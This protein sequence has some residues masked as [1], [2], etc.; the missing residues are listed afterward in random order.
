MGWR[1]RPVSQGVGFWCCERCLWCDRKGWRCVSKCLLAQGHVAREG[2]DQ[3]ENIEMFARLV[4]DIEIAV[5]GL[6]HQVWKQKLK[7]FL[8]LIHAWHTFHS[9]I[10]LEPLR[11]LNSETQSCLEYP[12][13]LLSPH[14]SGSTTC[15]ASPFSIT[16]AA[17]YGLA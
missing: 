9:R 15:A 11:S 14:S 2:M 7:P 8:F 3:S 17:P 10:K 5:Y 6:D 16:L 13:R 1:G 4:R 12:K